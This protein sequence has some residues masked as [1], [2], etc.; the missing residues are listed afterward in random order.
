MV[1]EPSLKIKENLHHKPDI[2]NL[3]VSNDYD[4]KQ[5]L[6]IKGADSKLTQ[7]HTTN[8]NSLAES[9]VTIHRLTPAQSP[10]LA[11][12]NEEVGSKRAT[13]DQLSPLPVHE[14]Q[15]SQ[16]KMKTTTEAS[17]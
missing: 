11:V 13:K 15:L 5:Q 3:V 1:D 4:L 8:H 10:K 2:N 17:P 7:G 14:Y 9:A 16:Q 12:Y 6:G